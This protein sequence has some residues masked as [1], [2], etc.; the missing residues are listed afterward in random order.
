M[1]T[2]RILAAAFVASAFIVA[3]ATR[4][5]GQEASLE[6]A[7]ERRA[8]IVSQ[9]AAP[10]APGAPATVRTLSQMP[11]V[12]RVFMRNPGEEIDEETR[13]LHEQD[14]AREQSTRQLIQQYRDAESG[15]D[16]SELQEKLAQVVREHFEIRQQLREKEL[17]ALEARVRR[18]RELHEKRGDAKDEIV[19]QRI[20]Q[21]IREAEGLGWSSGGDG[22]HALRVPGG[23]M[24]PRLQEERVLNLR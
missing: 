1:L 21:L 10:A 18:L 13:A 5:G 6:P 3:W 23:L 22:P 7:A 11:V 24:A 8:V 20:A 17:A 15:G 4:S 12:G 2:H 14:R 16:R 19:E 9:P